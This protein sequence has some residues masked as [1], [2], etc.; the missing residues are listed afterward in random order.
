MRNHVLAALAA[1]F[2]AACAIEDDREVT[3]TTSLSK[4]GD[5]IAYVGH[6]ALFAADGTEL[7]PDVPFVFATQARY[8]QTLE[9]LVDPAIAARSRAIVAELADAS[10]DERAFL[11]AQLVHALAEIVG[12]SEAPDYFGKSDTL[13]DVY[14]RL[15]PT[16]LAK[17]PGIEARLR[18]AGLG[19]APAA[20]ASSYE[21]DCIDAGVPVPPPWGS[22]SWLYSGQ[23]MKPFIS[24]NRLAAVY[25]YS[26]DRGTCIALPRWDA[27]SN[28]IALL[29]VICHGVQTS[30]ACFWDNKG[31]PWGSFVAMASFVK[32]N[33]ADIAKGGECTNCHAGENPFII[34]PNTPLD[35][36]TKVPANRWTTKNWYDPLIHASLAQNPGPTNAIASLPVATGQGSCHSC[37]SAQRLPE[38]SQSTYGFCSFVFQNAIGTGPNGAVKTMPPTVPSSPCA[39]C[40][41][42]AV[43]ES[44]Q[45]FDAIAAHGVA[46]AASPTIPAVLDYALQISALE[47]RCATPASARCAPDNAKIC[48]Q[49][50]GYCEI[51]TNNT[52]RHDLCRWPNASSASACGSTAGGWT[53]WDSS[54]AAGWPTAVPAGADGACITQ[55]QNIGGRPSTE[56]TCT[57]ANRE[58]CRVRGG[59]CENA[60][61][62]TK[63]ST[64]QLCRWPNHDTEAKC[65]TTA[66]GW[67]PKGF[68]FDLGWPSAL[69]NDELG[70]CITQMANIGGTPN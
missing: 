44:S 46:S 19:S 3:V 64:H 49:A 59:F 48:A 1:L 7:T 10:D 15:R 50:G 43:A 52:G 41:S 63:T 30:K 69:R 21:T 24:T 27:G 33:T 17:Y 36:S 70:A 32:G 47:A 60:I 20:E 13:H 42:G 57:A 61:N 9:A 58:R 62:K 5:P 53:A 29:G 35:L 6:G 65:M 26:N 16:A 38:L 56:S 40:H 37:H 18:T 31:V 34:H 28:T 12:G 68:A 8:R 2:G 11:D 22:A 54:F 45:E 23:L 66:G 25:Y 4:A 51:A 39:S 55:M 67:T 14:R